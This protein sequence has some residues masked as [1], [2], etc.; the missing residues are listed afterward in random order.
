MVVGRY[1][2]K[3]KALTNLMLTAHRI[4]L[5][6]YNFVSISYY[7]RDRWTATV[8]RP[9]CGIIVYTHGLCLDM[10]NY[11]FIYYLNDLSR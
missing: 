10:I 9:I 7:H 1:S 6:I 11:T 5:Q 3:I 4:H 8:D 2:N